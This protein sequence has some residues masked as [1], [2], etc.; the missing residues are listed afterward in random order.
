MVAP[1]PKLS[2]FDVVFNFVDGLFK[3]V[4]VG[5]V[6][7]VLLIL[8]AIGMAFVGFMTW[9]LTSAIMNL[10]DWAAWTITGLVEASAVI[11]MIGHAR[12]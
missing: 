11:L 7:I 2:V 8:V 5:A 6:M 1:A 4:A 12:K 9:V 10:Q 3:L